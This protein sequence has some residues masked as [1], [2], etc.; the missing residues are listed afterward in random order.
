[1]QRYDRKL[2]QAKARF[3]KT[4]SNNPMYPNPADLAHVVMA[5][6]AGMPTLAGKLS[7]E[8]FKDWFLNN[9]HNKELMEVGAG[10]AIEKLI[11]ILQDSDV[12]EKGAAS[13]NNQVASAKILLEMAGYG[14]SK[15]K[16]VEYKDKEIGNMDEEELEDFLRK[17]GELIVKA[18]KGE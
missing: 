8:G 13:V 5:Q 2:K 14:P 17:K 16:T 4:V 10:Y 3:W 12:G 7:E 18:V 1:M 9:Q 11:D 15:N 6:A